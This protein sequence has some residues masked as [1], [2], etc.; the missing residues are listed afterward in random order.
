[1]APVFNG[2]HSLQQALGHILAQTYRPLEIIVTD[3]ES[4]DRTA[5]FVVTPS[6]IGPRRN[7]IKAQLEVVQEGDIILF[8]DEFPVTCKALDE[9]IPRWKESGYNFA[10]L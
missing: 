2:E 1:L 8:H 4:P 10:K 5:A 3:D 7:V 6:T 9:V